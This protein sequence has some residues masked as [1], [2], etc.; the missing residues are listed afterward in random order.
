MIVSFPYRIATIYGLN[1]N[2][3]AAKQ[4]EVDCRVE[5]IKPNGP[6]LVYQPGHQDTANETL[7]SRMYRCAFVC[8]GACNHQFTIRGL[9]PHG[10]ID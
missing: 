1:V 10:V 3:N 8:V 5:R 4:M 9:L 2:H 7:S 6:S